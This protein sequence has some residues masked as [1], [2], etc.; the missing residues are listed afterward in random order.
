VT[1]SPVPPSQPAK[2]RASSDA[3][4]PPHG[5]LLR[6]GWVGIAQVAAIAAIDRIIALMTLAHSPVRVTNRER[7]KT[8]AHARSI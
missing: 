5:H 7:R 3:T 1:G 2:S 6:H 4:H 8:S